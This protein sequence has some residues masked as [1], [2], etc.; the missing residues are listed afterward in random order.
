VLR[1]RALEETAP[2]IVAAADGRPDADRP[3][4]FALY[5]QNVGLVQPLIAEELRAASELFPQAWI[6]EAF[7]QAV[8]YNK[9]SWRYVKR[10]LERWATEGR[11]ADAAARDRAPSRGRSGS[12]REWVQT[13]RPGQSMPDL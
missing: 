7:Q 13:Y 12:K 1:D 2:T 3:D 9:R 4:I 10:I 6:E 11:D 5:E 8:T